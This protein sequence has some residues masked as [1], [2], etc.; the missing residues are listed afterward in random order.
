M[1]TVHYLRTAALIAIAA[2]FLKAEVHSMQE[3]RQKQERT[4]K[5][6]EERYKPA[7]K[8]ERQRVEAK[9]QD[10]ERT[11][12]RVTVRKTSEP[13]AVRHKEQEE[14][15]RRT[16]EGYRPTRYTSQPQRSIV[17]VLPRP[18]AP[19]PPHRRPGY[20]I[21]R[22]P[23]LSLTLS[24]GG[25]VYFYHDYLFYRHY[26]TGYVVVAPPLGALVPTLP[27]GYVVIFTLGR[28]YYVYENTYYIWDDGVVAYRVVEAPYVEGGEDYEYHL[29]DIVEQLPDGAQTV[30]IKGVQYYV[31]Q[32]IY[33]LP[34]V[35]N[36][37]IVYIVVNP[38]KE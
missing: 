11:D 16:Y 12:K 8:A 10:K 37:E 9:Q 2:S 21:P 4:S 3:L 22:L 27:V 34:S 5:Q 28:Y 26:P 7:P 32:G 33:F 17:R 31:Y 1:Q 38:A 29:G 36:G 13:K 19:L 15:R 23:A 18:V 35:Q 30:S 20:R 24:V 25:I 14:Y 6:S